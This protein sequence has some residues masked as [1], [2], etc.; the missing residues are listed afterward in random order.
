MIINSLLDTDLYKFTMMQAVLH[1][2]PGAQVEYRSNAG[3]KALRWRRLPMRVNREVDALCTCASPM[4]SFDYLRGL[5]YVKRTSSI[6]WR[7]FISIE[8]IDIRAAGDDLAIE[9]KG[10]WL[11][12]PFRGYRFWQSSTRSLRR[13]QPAPDLEEGRRRLAAK[14][15]LVNTLSPVYFVRGLRHASPLFAPV[16]EGGTWHGQG[17]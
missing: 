16:A 1:Q 3:M 6:F 7:Y 2:F 4:T 17:T 12:H 11:H 14:L 13:T 9:I 15:D 5:R 8:N 10:P